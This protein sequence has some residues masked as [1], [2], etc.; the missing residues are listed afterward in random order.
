MRVRVCSGAAPERA[1]Q[2]QHGVVPQA[3]RSSGALLLQEAPPHGP[4]LL[5]PRREAAVQPHRAHGGCSV[6]VEISFYRFFY[7]FILQKLS[8]ETLVYRCG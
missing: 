7:S 8:V 5:H 2:E 6:D 4:R 3:E 1:L